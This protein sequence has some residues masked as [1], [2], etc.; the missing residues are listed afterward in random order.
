MAERVVAPFNLDEINTS[1]A[2]K[3]VVLWKRG[4]GLMCGQTPV[5]EDVTEYLQLA[6]AATVKAIKSRELLGYGPDMHLADEE[7]VAVTDQLLIEDSALSR[8]W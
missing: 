2:M 6:C 7:C 4:K 8:C 5:G 3:F 1:S